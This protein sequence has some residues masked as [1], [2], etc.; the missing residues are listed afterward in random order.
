LENADQTIIALDA[1]MAR[2]VELRRAIAARDVA[3]V[4]RII[5]AA[6]KISRVAHI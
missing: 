1:C 3:A 4:C 2:L 6:N 5:H